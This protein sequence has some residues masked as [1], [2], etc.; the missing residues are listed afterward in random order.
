MEFQKIA[1]SIC[2]LLFV[3][4]CTYAQ[5]VTG[6]LVGTVVDPAGSVIPGVK[7]T[8]TNQ[9][10][11][12]GMAATADSAGLFRLIPRPQSRHVQRYGYG[13]RGQDPPGTGYSRR[14]QREPRLG[15]PATRDRQRQGRGH[16]DGRGDAGPDLQ[17]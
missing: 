7:I 3:I 17:L 16:G 8:L 11:A 2:L 5:T 10:T 15:T 12:A 1:K 14:S 4:A 13:H 6:S 9:G